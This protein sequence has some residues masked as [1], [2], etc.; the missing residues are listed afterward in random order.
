[1][2]WCLPLLVALLL[3][4]GATVA[5]AEIYAFDGQWGGASREIAVDSHGDVYASGTDGVRRSDGW[6]APIA[7]Y[8][9]GQDVYGV[10]VHGDT[11]YAGYPGSQYLVPG[12]IYLVSSRGTLLG[13]WNGTPLAFYEPKG[14][15]T[16]SAGRLW[17][18]DNLNN[19]VRS[20]W[21]NGTASVVLGSGQNA[22]LY[23]PWD[24]AVNTTGYIF[25]TAF[26]YDDTIKDGYWLHVYR[27]NGSVA[28][29]W[30]RNG[31][32]PGELGWPHGIAVDAGGNVFV[33]DTL[34]NRI[35]K[36][37][38]DG[39]LLASFGGYIDTP[40]IGKGRLRNPLGVAVDAAGTVFVADSGGGL[41]QRFRQVLAVPGGAGAPT[42]SGGDGLCDD[43]NGNGRKDFAD[44][45]LYFNQMTWIAANEP[46]IAFDFNGNGRIDFADV[47]WLFNNL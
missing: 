17:V 20:F 33:A 21:P 12:R 43:V 34:N 1:M 10:A 38:P 37:G 47:V 27:P 16:D 4:S 18:A 7:Q 36:F 11:I 44:V 2:Q 9:P 26:V 31:T 6:G 35:Q 19:R 42:P 24:V 30:G 15:G 39:T 28:A 13:Q 45:V 25:V 5:A 46:I 22:D 23:R 14:L 3:C 29:R 8:V 40:F 41:V 32:A